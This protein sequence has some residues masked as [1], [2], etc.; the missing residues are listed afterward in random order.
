MSLTEFIVRMHG[1]LSSNFLVRK[2]IIKVNVKMYCHCATIA[3]FLI[4]TCLKSF[5][6]E[7]CV[8]FAWTSLNDFRFVGLFSMSPL[9]PTFN[10]SLFAATLDAWLPET[11]F[12]CFGNN[13]CFESV[14]G[15]G[16][17]TLNETLLVDLEKNR[18][19]YYFL[20]SLLY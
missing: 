20:W 1:I 14:D 15:D 16:D 13:C 5:L 3:Y 12:C 6:I 19:F 17:R 18:T 2:H 11:R 7:D 8:K 9:L 4:Q 10:L